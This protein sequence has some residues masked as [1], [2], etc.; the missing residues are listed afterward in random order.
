MSLSLYQEAI[1]E[2]KQLKDVAEQNAKNKIIEALMPQIQLMIEQ[3]LTDEFDEEFDEET[4]ESEEMVEELPPEELSSLSSPQPPT[5]TLD[6]GSTVIIDSEPEVEED[7]DISLDIDGEINLDIEGQEEEEEEEEEDLLLSKAGVEMLESHIHRSRNRKLASK[8][9]V[10]NK[11]IKTLREAVDGIDFR[12]LKLSEKKIALT[13]Y[14]K[15]LNEVF[16]LSQSVIIMSESV[17]ER[18]EYRILGM[19]KE[20]K[21]MSRKKDRSAFRR[22]FEELAQD[23]G[24]REQEDEIAVEDELEVE[25]EVPGAEE[26]DVDAATGALEDLGAALGLDVSVDAEGEEEVEVEEEEG[27]ELEL[28]EGDVEEMYEISETAIRRELRRMRRLREQEEGRAAEADPA[29]AHGGED[30]GDVFI[31]VDEDT[32]LNALADELGDPGVPTPTVESRRR[33]ARRVRRSSRRVNESRRRNSTP[34]TRKTSRVG[35]TAVRENVR[36][37]K[38]L[39]EMNLFNAKLLFA[40][41]LM[42][43]RG[44]STKQQRAIVEALDKASTIKEAKL[45]YQGLSN[46][47]QRRS[48]RTLS[49][50]SSRLLSS[51]SRSTRS[52]APAQSGVE[53]DR[54]AVLAGL[55]NK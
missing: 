11:R 9:S 2:A 10:L 19:L 35:R 34:R 21:D 51:S 44:L 42:Q 23:E 54:W 18:L 13:Y 29:L 48:G 22:L 25:E 33:R 24:L 6:L 8:V 30:E 1:I 17:D 41:K 15:L 53:V 14:G 45:L 26:V 50:G 32:L 38:Q 4:V 40:N 3:Q 46:S 37:K 49:E 12:R 47:L 7:P 43:N 55:N 5:A 31:D 20:I 28:E 16:S 36:L 39:Q 27:V 52:A